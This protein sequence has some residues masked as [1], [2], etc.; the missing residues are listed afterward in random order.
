MRLMLKWLTMTNTLA[1]YD[2]AKKL[3]QKVIQYNPEVAAWVPHMFS[4]FHLVQIKTLL[5]TQQ[6]P[7]LEKK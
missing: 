5:I 7:K 4:N 2:T 6:P 1:Y 3:P